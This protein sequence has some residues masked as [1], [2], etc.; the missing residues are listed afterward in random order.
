MEK[1]QFWFE[2]WFDSPYYHELYSDRDENEAAD[3]IDKLI[4]FLHPSANATM[5]DV[6]CGKGRH[7]IQLASKGFDVT[8]IDLSEKSIKAALTAENDK[9]HFYRHDMRQPFRINYF[10]YAF[11]FFT[12]FGYFDSYRENSNAMRTMVQSLKNKGTLIID[13]LNVPYAEN[14]FNDGFTK[15]CGPVTYCIKKWQDTRH[16]FK[17]IIIEDKRT[18]SPIIYTEKVAKFLLSD[19]EGFLRE[20]G[21]II[22]NLWGDYKLSTY[23]SELSGRLIISAKKQ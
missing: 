5:L 16:F 2:D 3:F 11:N 15:V 7:A 20:Q 19:F 1:Q 12:S 21:M 17:Q 6:A 13:Y 14:H 10:D 8:G 18:V 4:T 22:E 23:N 9:L